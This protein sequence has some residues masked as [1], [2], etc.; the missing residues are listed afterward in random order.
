[1]DNPGGV[2]IL[3]FASKTGISSGLY[4]QL[5]LDADLTVFTFTHFPYSFI[6]S[7]SRVW[8]I[9]LNSLN[10]KSKS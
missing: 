6:I 3:L 5:R 2:E 10:S 7:N 4:G 1:M 9:S 8:S